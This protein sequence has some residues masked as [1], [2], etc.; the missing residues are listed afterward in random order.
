MAGK[1]GYSMI[2]N[3]KYKISTLAKD[4]NIKNKDLL[5]LVTALGMEDRK[6]SSVIEA[7]EFNLILEALTSKAQ[8]SNF[9]DYMAGKVTIVKVLSKEELEAETKVREEKEAEEKKKEKLLFKLIIQIIMQ[10]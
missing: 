5:D 9:D 8:V 7:D 4:L 10:L 6:H 2:N 3:T 1:D